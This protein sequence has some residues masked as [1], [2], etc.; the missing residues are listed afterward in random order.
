MA[1]LTLLRQACILPSISFTVSTV[2]TIVANVS[3]KRR[4]DDEGVFKIKNNVRHYG[5]RHFFPTAVEGC[6]KITLILNPNPNPKNLKINET[7]FYRGGNKIVAYGFPF[8]AQLKYRIGQ[9]HPYRT[10][11]TARSAVI[12]YSTHRMSN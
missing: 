4:R 2:H 10:R 1:P 12:H 9:P 8:P 7:S 11:H 5:L 6:P 3:F